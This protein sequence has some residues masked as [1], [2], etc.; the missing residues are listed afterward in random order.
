MNRPPRPPLRRP[1]PRSP[2]LRRAPRS[3]ASP[4]NALGDTRCVDLYVTL[5][6]LYVTAQ[7]AS[8]RAGRAYG[9][10]AVHRD[11]RARTVCE[12]NRPRSG[13]T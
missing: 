5:C 12:T 10:C 9:G 6:T 8:L 13:L 3:P 4:R 7:W 1:S 2:T 11:L